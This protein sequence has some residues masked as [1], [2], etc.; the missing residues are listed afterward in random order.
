M[1]LK[2]KT[3]NNV[4]PLISHLNPCL[5]RKPI[6]NKLDMSKNLDWS[7]I[8]NFLKYCS[9]FIYEAFPK[10]GTIFKEIQ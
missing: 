9:F 8:P 5:K 4:S 1:L 2:L 3:S 6:R 10:K 7:K